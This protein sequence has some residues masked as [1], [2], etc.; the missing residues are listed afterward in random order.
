MRRIQ[1]ALLTAVTVIGITSIASAADMPMKAA[2]MVAPVAAYN[3]TGFYVGVNA[4]GTWGNSTATE[5]LVPG[6]VAYNGIGNSWS[7]K[8]SGFVGGGQIG[9]NWQPVGSPLVLGVEADFG[10]LGLNG[11][12][13]SPLAVTQASGTKVA[14][15]GNFYS[16][17]RGRLG[18]AANNW[19]LYGTGGAIFANVKGQITDPVFATP[20]Q[21]SAQTGWQTG[22]TAGG[23]VE[24]GFGVWSVKAEYLYFNLGTKNVYATH[25]GVDLGHAWDIKTTG[26]IARVG[27]N[28]RFSGL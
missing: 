3:W 17:A 9:Y 15:S 14:T 26:S 12:A 22:W 8:S 5:T 21:P 1:C 18:Y 7:S 11:S 16:T 19:L 10:Y 25:T 4:G 2:P 13:V 24:Y 28:Y 6:S 27:L 20:I 23:G